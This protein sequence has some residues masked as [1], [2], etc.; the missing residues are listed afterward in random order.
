M[1]WG[2]RL[3]TRIDPGLLVGVSLGDWTG[4]LWDNGFRIRPPY[5]PK[6]ADPFKA[7]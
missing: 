1:G 7:A 6:V 4:V 2:K 3:L 5:W